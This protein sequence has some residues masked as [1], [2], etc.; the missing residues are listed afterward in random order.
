MGSLF[1]T[2]EIVWDPV[3]QT[4]VVKK[5]KVIMGGTTSGGSGGMFVDATPT[6]ASNLA[7]IPPGSTFPVPMT[8]QQMWDLL[9]Y[10][11]L[12]PAFTSFA[13]TG[14]SLLECGDA[15]NGAAVQFTWTDT[16]PAN[17]AANT[18]SIADAVLGPIE[19]NISIV[20]PK[21]H[22]FVA[23]PI[24]FDVIGSDLFT[25]SAKNTHGATFT[26]TYTVN[27][28]WREYIGEQAAAGNLAQAAIKALAIVNQ[29]NS[30]CGGSYVFPA[31]ATYK[32]FA[33]PVAWVQPVSFKD[34]ATGFNV[35][36][37]APYVVAVTNA[38]GQIENYD[39]YRTTNIIGGAIT[40]QV[41]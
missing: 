32:T 2:D 29:V 28:N 34:A 3:K 19:H 13:I 15:I 14:I 39:V 23:T 8:M 37:Q 17:I 6:T 20:S 35:P 25:I 22:S 21:V 1:K 41:V 27:W 38:F 7:G 12:V 24:E 40:I 9:L 5:K 18:L 31:A 11:Y 4:W 26:D 16:N 36:M 30:A 33:F 10:P